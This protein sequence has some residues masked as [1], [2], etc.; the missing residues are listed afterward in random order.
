M[1]TAGPEHDRVF[2]VEVKA[3]GK[4]WQAKAGSKRE[5]ERLSALKAIE[6][7]KSEE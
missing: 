3:C 5:A 2:T 6:E 7:L 4:T 1:E